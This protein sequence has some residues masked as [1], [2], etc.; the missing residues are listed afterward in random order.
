M[1]WS[2]GATFDDG[3]NFSFDKTKSPPEFQYKT[4][5]ND[6]ALLST[7]IVGLIANIRTSVGDLQPPSY[8][9]WVARYSLK[10]Y[11]VAKVYISVIW[12]IWVA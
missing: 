12:L 11:E 1:F 6:Y 2:I 9:Y 5:F 4:D 7:G 10:D 8:D 3:D